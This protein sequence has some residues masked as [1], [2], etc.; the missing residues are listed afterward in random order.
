MT[1][2]EL[3]IILDYWNYYERKREELTAVMAYC[4]SI[5]REE[6]VEHYRTERAE[7]DRAFLAFDHMLSDLFQSVV[8]KNRVEI[9]TCTETLHGKYVKNKA[10]SYRKL[11]VV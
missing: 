9:V 2:A 8:N 4:E 11:K 6:R 1:N 7:I 10:F 5:M 3:K